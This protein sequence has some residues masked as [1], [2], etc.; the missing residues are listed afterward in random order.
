MG[1]DIFVIWTKNRLKTDT[2]LEVARKVEKHLNNKYKVLILD[3]NVEKVEWF[4]TPKEPLFQTQDD[5]LID[6]E[7]EKELNEKTK[8]GET[9]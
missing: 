8:K 6:L 2:S 9:K 4:E 5:E 1:K 3:S 7:L